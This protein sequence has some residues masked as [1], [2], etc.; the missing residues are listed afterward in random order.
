MSWPGRNE[1]GRRPGGGEKEK[2]GGKRMGDGSQRK[3]GQ[4][5]G[6]TT[7]RDN[8]HMPTGQPIPKAGFGR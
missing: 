5:K 7:A 2:S 1:A 3:R 4:E 8:S 6:G